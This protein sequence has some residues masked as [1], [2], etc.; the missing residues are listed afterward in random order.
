[1]LTLVDSLL[2]REAVTFALRY[3]CE[4]CAHFDDARRLC[5]EGYPNEPHVED[6]MRSADTLEFCKS[7]E[8][9]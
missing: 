2:R 6:R 8:L 1:M 4:S 5:A 9:A 7:F 3:T